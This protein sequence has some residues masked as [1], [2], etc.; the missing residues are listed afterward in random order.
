MPYPT[1]VLWSTLPFGVEVEFVHARLGDIELLDG[2]DWRPEDALY[3]DGGMLTPEDTSPDVRGGEVGSPILTWDQ[4]DQIAT[5]ADR[6]RA[7]G[8][9][10][11]WSCGLHVHVSLEPWGKAILLPLLDAAITGEDALRR[12]LRPAA[13]RDIFLPRTTPRVRDRF[14]AARTPEEFESDFLYDDG[15]WSARG[16]V[17]LRSWADYGTV[18]IRLPNGS[19]DAGEILTAVEV[20]LKWVAA[21]GRGATLPASPE[22]LAEAAKSYLL[23][24]CFRPDATLS[25]CSSASILR[26][27]AVSSG[28]SWLNG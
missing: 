15:P 13:H 3:D 27:T 10:A 8:G 9:R 11:N 25:A 14:L 17:N 2:W 22:A 4:R 21:V 12:L 16:G 5:M 28:N 1:P 24:V 26:T 19:L 7:T 23:K 18:E 20:C 6:L